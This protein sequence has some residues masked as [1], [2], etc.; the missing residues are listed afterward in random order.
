MATGQRCGS[1]KDPLAMLAGQKEITWQRC[2][3]QKDPLATLACKKVGNTAGSRK[4]ECGRVLPTKPYNSHD[5]HSSAPALLESAYRALLR[6]NNSD[7]SS[8]PAPTESAYRALLR[9]NGHS[10]APAPTESAYRALLRLNGHSSA[11]ALLE[12]AYRALLRSN[13][14]DPSSAPTLW[15]VR[16]EPCSAAITATPAA[17]QRQPRL[18]SFS[19]LS[20]GSLFLEIQVQAEQSAE[21]VRDETAVTLAGAR[22]VAASSLGSGWSREQPCQCRAYQEGAHRASLYGALPSLHSRLLFALVGLQTVCLGSVSRRSIAGS[23]VD[24]DY[25]ELCSYDPHACSLHFVRTGRSFG[26]PPLSVLGADWD[27]VHPGRFLT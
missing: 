9:L 1:Q 6:S 27:R 19:G 20:G 16:I 23:G 7:P 14:S 11:P 18:E 26:Q 2:G 5:N 12:S 17:H 25:K 8:A 13:N 15:R 4:S 10:R 24:E 3:S 22:S 21:Q